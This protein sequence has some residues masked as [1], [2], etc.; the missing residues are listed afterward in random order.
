M[1]RAAQEGG[2]S[3]AEHGGH[4][5]AAKQ[6]AAFHAGIGSVPK[7]VRVVEFDAAPV[8]GFTLAL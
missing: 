5:A 7:H 3:A 4:I 8:S 2:T 6:G 1:M